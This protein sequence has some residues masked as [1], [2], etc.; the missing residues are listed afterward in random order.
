MYI[1]PLFIKAEMSYRYDRD[2]GPSSHLPGPVG[3]TERLARASR[4]L[5]RTL[6]PTTARPTT[7]RQDHNEHRVRTRA[8]PGRA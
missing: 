2:R 5:W 3:L 4:S 7:A 6:R 8:T 1:D